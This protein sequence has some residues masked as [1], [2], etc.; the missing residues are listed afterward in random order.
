MEE[1]NLKRKGIIVLVLFVGL[2]LIIATT[3]AIK[4]GGPN[5]INSNSSLSSNNRSMIFINKGDIYSV[6]LD[7]SALQR[8]TTTSLREQDP[9]YS[10]DG[11]TICFGRQMQGQSYDFDDIYIMDADGTNQRK[12]LAGQAGYINMHF[13]FAPDGKRILFHRNISDPHASGPGGLSEVNVDGTGFKILGGY[14]SWPAYFID[15]KSVYGF[16]GP[17]I[18]R[19]NLDNHETSVVGKVPAG[20]TEVRYS[21]DFKRI[22]FINLPEEDR[23]TSEKYPYQVYIADIDGSNVKKLTSDPGPKHQP[24]FTQDGSK[25]I[26]I[27]EEQNSERRAIKIMNADGNDIRTVFGQTATAVKE[28][29]KA[30]Y[31][32]KESQ[33]RIKYGSG[34]LQVKIGD[35][36]ENIIKALGK[37]SE[38]S[39]DY[40]TFSQIGVQCLLKDNKVRTIFLFFRSPKH[41]K[42]DGATDK[43]IGFNSSISDVLKA[44]GRPTRRGESTLSEFGAKPGAQE[45]SL[46]YNAAGI[47][48]TFW[49]NELADIRIYKAE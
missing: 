6:S 9:V 42:F 41:S 26:F 44:Y 27:H 12:I 46:E 20:A 16:G 18:L 39:G 10:P 49:D 29:P 31:K 13:A 22:I 14:L 8:L 28:K 15:G 7:G 19:V 23:M 47:T 34:F 43:G 5:L 11:K 40:I 17:E 3:T 32:A 1:G 21:P 33:Q 24:T 45:V 25:I 30:M 4:S 48:F 37:P 35:S 38:I 2:I 36:E